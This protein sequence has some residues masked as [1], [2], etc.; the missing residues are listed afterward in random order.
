MGRKGDLESII[1]SWLAVFIAL[2]ILGACQSSEP[3]ASV[4]AQTAE[5]ESWKRELSDQDE[6]EILAAMRSARPEKVGEAQVTT[7]PDRG[8]W[9]DV[10]DA[11]RLAAAEVEM[12]VITK[13]RLD[14][15]NWVFELLTVEEKPVELRVERTDDVLIWKASAT[16][17]LFNND[18]TRRDELLSAF[19][20]KMRQLSRKRK[21]AE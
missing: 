10:P 3:A 21:F 12:S 14:D 18:I 17:G 11:A 20:E 4:R 7:G 13:S 1:A 19:E 8:R 5:D 2:M 16:V 15:R 9:S 6:R